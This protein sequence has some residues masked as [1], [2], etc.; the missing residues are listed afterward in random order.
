MQVIFENKR[1]LVRDGLVLKPV[2]GRKCTERYDILRRREVAAAKD[3]A[4]VKKM[5]FED[6]TKTQQDCKGATQPRRKG[7]EM[8]TQKV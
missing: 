8:D 6:F 1:R 3:G 2:H 7:G 5:T 4:K